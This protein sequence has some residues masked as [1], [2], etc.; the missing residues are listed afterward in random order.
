MVSP[1]KGSFAV[2]SSYRM[3]PSDHTSE[4]TSA[5]A[6][7]ES[8]SGDMY[9][10]DPMMARS[11]VSPCCLADSAVLLEMPK[12]STLTVTAFFAF[13]ARNRFAGLRSRWTMPCACASRDRFRRLEQV[14]D[15]LGDGQGAARFELLLEVASVEIFHHH[16]GRAV[17][18]RAHVD[19]PADVLPRQLGQ[20][21]RLAG[22]ARHQLVALHRFGQEELDGDEL[23]ELQVRRRNDDAH[24]TFAED[25]LDAVL[26]GEGFADGDGRVLQ[27]PLL[28]GR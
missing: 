19:D 12:S 14:V 28:R 21:S 26:A 17:V 13:F 24:R 16:E 27:H 11:W 5:S 3:T 9:K 20:H 23:L 1:P 8:C 22:E 10:G 18:G 25:P 6:A 4:R 2:V 15:G 7:R